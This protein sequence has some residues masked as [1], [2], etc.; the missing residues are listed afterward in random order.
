MTNFSQDIR[1]YRSNKTDSNGNFREDNL[2]LADLN[3]TT[4]DSALQIAPL[5]HWQDDE[6]AMGRLVIDTGFEGEPD[7]LP[8][9]QEIAMP[10]TG[11]TDIFLGTREVLPILDEPI[12]QLVAINEPVVPSRVSRIEPLLDGIGLTDQANERE[13]AIKLA[14]GPLKPA[15]VTP[16]PTVMPPETVMPFVVESFVASHRVMRTDFNTGQNGAA[17]ND[18]TETELEA[19]AEEVLQE[20]KT[21][22]FGAASAAAETP[23][24]KH[25]DAIRLPV[26]AITLITV[27][28]LSLLAATVSLVMTITTLKTEVGRLSALVAIVKDDVEVLGQK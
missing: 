16:N 19:V 17:D 15:A 2:I 23:R 26:W 5:R 12:T 6:E 21:A 4:D 20:D 3:A 1:P 7:A 8:H 13:A 24:D 27:T 28:L 14:K 10:D 22:T 9:T 11:K 18:N 25:P